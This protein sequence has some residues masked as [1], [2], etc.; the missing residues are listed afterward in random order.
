MMIR[1]SFLTVF[2]LAV[3]AM[4][5][6]LE[7]KQRI[8]LFYD[9]K[10]PQTAFAAA[11]IGR[12]A[13]GKGDLVVTE[14]LEKL[15]AANDG[16]R[17]A[18]ASSAA[19]SRRL[20]S[21]LQVPPL[22]AVAPQAYA[23]RR[24]RA[25]AQTTY[26]VL[27]ADSAGAM[28]GA[29]DIAE[30]IRLGTL[31]GVLDGEHA[32]HISQRGIKFNIT[33]DR[34]T[35]TYSDN[36]DSAQANIP[37]V[38]DIAFWHEY[39]D[40]MARAR[41]NVLSLWS[42]HPF[43]SLVEVPEYPDIALND[44]WGNREK[45][46]LNFNM[47]SNAMAKPFQL[48]NVEIVK[49]MTIGDKVKFWREVMQYAK[50]RGIDVYWFTWNIFVWGTE[51]KH[52]LTEDGQNGETIRYFRASVREMVRTYPLLAGIGI[53][54]GENMKTKQGEF[55]HEAWLWQTYGEGIR[56]ALKQQ[57]SRQFRLIHRYHMTAQKQVL[58]TFKDYP[59]PFDFSFKYSVAHMYSEVN[60]PFI[61]PVLEKMPRNMRTWLTVRNDDIYSYRWGDPDFAR[62]YVRNI[63]GPDR[64]AGFY[65]GPDG[66]CWGREFSDR[67]PLTP[68]Q[69]VM[70]KQWYS[71]MMW[72]RLS[73]DPD[74]PNALFERTLAER[75]PRVPGAKLYAA[76]ESASKVIPQTT[77][78]FWQDLDFQWLPEACVS[79]KGFYSV[80]DFVSGVTMP[81]SGILNV[82]QWRSR[83][84]K[85]ATMEG[86]TPPQV[87]AAL[88]ES[89]A[90]ALALVAQMRP[91]QGDDRELRMTLGDVEA[92]AHLGN[93]YAGKILAAADLARFD[94]SGN[95]AQKASAVEHLGAALA[96]WKKYAA[97][98]SSQY[99]P[100]KLGR[101]GLVIDLNELTAKAAADIAIAEN[102][103]TGTVKDDGEGPV[104]GDINFRQ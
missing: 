92:M 38:W 89:A 84:E 25:G 1:A 63:P 102:W 26:V 71:F 22:Q 66:Y 95:A 24:K 98:A 5:A 11:E 15:P 23:L 87:A 54:A 50:G 17:I 86:I 20:A 43:P 30:A 46:D 10:V 76:L 6:Q 19:E 61:A 67:E 83:L 75:F 13:A 57:P 28:Y 77:R 42:L 70:Q 34:R 4:P 78:F 58:D 29:L 68:R 39:F 93:Y 21:S 79:R 74:L 82:R 44:V 3:A 9:A 49:K 12:A 100:Q 73:Y 18:V 37:E 8:A 62:D 35:P 94:R 51:G 33:L 53:T 59:G 103:S 7:A 31:A 101:I 56:D 88:R 96:D 27:G 47:N 85:G 52:G 99:K 16:I 90:K 91:R 104:K 60:P 81:G 72:G 2:A 32:P 65:M 64:V 48:K 69:L 41:F 80:A 14:G 97:V 40:E 45:F 55:D 36:S